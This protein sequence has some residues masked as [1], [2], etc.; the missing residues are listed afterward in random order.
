MINKIQSAE[1]YIAIVGRESEL[2]KEQE[3]EIDDV[4]NSTF[5]NYDKIYTNNDHEVE[6]IYKIPV[7]IMQNDKINENF[8]KNLSKILT[9]L[10]EYNPHFTQYKRGDV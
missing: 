9:E 4:F 10:R 3:R 7:P 6:I 5:A 2:G 1:L 8:F